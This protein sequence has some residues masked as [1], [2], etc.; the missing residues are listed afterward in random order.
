MGKSCCD[1]LCQPT[2]IILGGIAAILYVSCILWGSIT[3][4]T[5]R[6]NRKIQISHTQTTCL[7][8]NYTVF[9]HTCQSC[10]GSCNLYTCY[11]ETLH[12]SYPI[13]NQ[14]VIT[15]I[16][17]STDKAKPYEKTQV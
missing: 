8:L 3:A 15:T 5:Y 6:E 1:I 7:V 14:T 2:S 10:S 17:S 11:D 16:L 12:I 4:V 9:S 13:F